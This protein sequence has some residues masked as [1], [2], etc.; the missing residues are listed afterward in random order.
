MRVFSPQNLGTSKA[1]QARPKLTSA[2]VCGQK[3]RFNVA[4]LEQTAGLRGQIS[5]LA[6]FGLP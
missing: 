5:W 6:F 1:T 2:C 3:A 4:L